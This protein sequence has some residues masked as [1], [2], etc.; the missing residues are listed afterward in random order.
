MSGI[1]ND[2]RRKRRDENDLQWRVRIAQLDMAERDRSGPI[3][4]PQTERHGDYEDE[5]V[6]HVETN[7]LARTKRNRFSN[8]LIDLRDRG[9]ITDEQFTA[10]EEI[11]GAHQLITQE[12]GVRGSQFKAQVD[13]SGSNKGVLVERLAT[14]R[15]QVA[16]AKWRARLPTPK[17]L[18][19][20]MLT[21]PQAMFATAR[22]Y[23]VGWP[24]ARRLLIESLDRWID[25]R[26]WAWSNIDEEDIEA[27]HRRINGSR[28]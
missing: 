15:A 26:E 9:V 12:V 5:F 14:V 21:M 20:D 23:K 6:T 19:I 22:S 3:I 7:T 10:G 28:N 16:Y 25:V 13:C 8:P 18:V 27:S 17:A 1:A 4:T 2:D 24:R 11:Q